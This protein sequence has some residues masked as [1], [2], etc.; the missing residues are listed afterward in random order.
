MNTLMLQTH[1]M[2]A[3]SIAGYGMTLVRKGE[4]GLLVDVVGR[5]DLEVGK[6]GHLEQVRHPHQQCLHPVGEVGKVARINADTNRLVSK[7]NQG[8][9]YCTE[10]QYAGLDHVIGVDEG[11]K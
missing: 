6:E 11:E 9:P 5:G 1:Q 2:G 10:V 4:D 7:A 3:N 8:Q